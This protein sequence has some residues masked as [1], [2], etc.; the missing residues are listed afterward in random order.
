MNVGYPNA[1]NNK[2][3]SLEDIKDYIIDNRVKVL[4]AGCIAGYGL[5]FNSHLLLTTAQALATPSLGNISLLGVE[6]P[7]G[8]PGLAI[9]YGCSKLASGIFNASIEPFLAIKYSLTTQKNQFL[10]FVGDDKEKYNKKR[11]HEMLEKAFSEPGPKKERFSLNRLKV[12]VDASKEANPLASYDER[13]IA[14]MIQ[15]GELNY[16]YLEQIIATGTDQ[17]QLYNELVT[18]GVAVTK[19]AFDSEIEHYRDARLEKLRETI[20]FPWLE[21]IISAR[22]TEYPIERIYDALENEGWTGTPEFLKDEIDRCR[23]TRFEAINSK[24]DF[25]YLTQVITGGTTETEAQYRLNTIFIDLQKFGW[26]GDKKQ[27]VEIIQE[28]YNTIATKKQD[29]AKEA[30]RFESYDLLTHFLTIVSGAAIVGGLVYYYPLTISAARSAWDSGVPTLLTIGKTIDTAIPYLQ[31]KTSSAIRS[32][33]KNA[34][35]KLPEPVKELPSRISDIPG[36][37]ADKGE[38]VAKSLASWGWSKLAKSGN[39]LAKG[40]R[41]I[42]RSTLDNP[43]PA[44]AVT[45]AVY[46]AALYSFGLPTAG[47]IAVSISSLAATKSAYDWGM[48]L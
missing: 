12:Q 44:A 23:K 29:A 41:S 22:N 14:V 18:A 17:D 48:S 43:W 5:Y 24:I 28:T 32:L 8:I 35:K 2:S 10:T 45:S 30:E 25:E 46:A 4:V 26:P 11:I 6:L 15:S 13:V 20:D 27:L 36:K 16:S 42:Y 39:T 1:Y 34:Y 38:A 21:R 9:A 3:S 33:A 7:M 31:N 19:A 37:I 40:I 47:D